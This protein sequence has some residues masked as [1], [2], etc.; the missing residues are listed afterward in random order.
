LRV[1]VLEHARHL[2]S[3][4]T[5]ERPEAHLQAG[6]L[7]GFIET[8]NQVLDLRD[9]GPFGDDGDGIIEGVGLQ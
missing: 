6:V 9:I 3:G 8:R 4:H 7:G 1:N 2:F 5:V